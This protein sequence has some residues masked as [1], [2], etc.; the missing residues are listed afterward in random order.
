MNLPVLQN[1]VVCEKQF[2]TRRN[3]K[4]FCVLT[5]TPK[6]PMQTP[7]AVL[8]ISRSGLLLFSR[9]VVSL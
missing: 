7:F 2:L 9:L 3:S 5:N 4:H 6:I 8:L 1:S